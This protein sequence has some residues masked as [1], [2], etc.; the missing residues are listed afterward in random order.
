M[1]CDC[2]PAVTTIAGPPQRDEE[3]LSSEDEV[4]EEAEG[5]EREESE[6]EREVSRGEGSESDVMGDF[7]SPARLVTPTKRVVVDYTSD[8]SDTSAAEEQLSTPTK[9]PRRLSFSPRATSSAVRP[10]RPA[11]VCELCGAWGDVVVE[12]EGTAQYRWLLQ[13]SSTP[14]HLHSST[15]CDPCLLERTHAECELPRCKVCRDVA[16]TLEARWI[17][18]WA[19]GRT[20]ELGLRPGIQV[21]CAGKKVEW[22]E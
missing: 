12:G 21:Y 17:F 5:D 19:G 16:A 3:D 18:R 13:H 9:R 6:E 7:S 15:R 1:D 2:L 8:S 22:R 20:R 4:E 10:G 14:P 11:L